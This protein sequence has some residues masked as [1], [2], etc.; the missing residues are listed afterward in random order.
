MGDLLRPVWR[1]VAL[2]SRPRRGA[3]VRPGGEAFGA[4][5]ASCRL[6]RIHRPQLAIS[7]VGADEPINR[8]GGSRAAKIVTARSQT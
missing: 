6:R 7:G 1:C 2:L 8:F 3:T 4:G 5:G